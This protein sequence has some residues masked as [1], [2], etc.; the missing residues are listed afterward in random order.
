MNNDIY[1][2]LTEYSQVFRERFKNIAETTFTEMANEARVD[3]AT[4]HTT[5]KKIYKYEAQARSIKRRRYTFIAL[6]V[7]LWIILLF[8]ICGTLY[9]CIVDR[10]WEYT[11]ISTKTILVVPLIIIPVPLFAWIHPLIKKLTGEGRQIKQIIQN[12]YKEA[13]EQMEP[14]NRLYDWDVLT[15]M[16]TQTVPKLEFD[17]YFTTQRLADLKETYGWDDSFNQDRSVIYSHSGLIKGNPFIICRTRRMEMGFKTYE[18]YKTI[19]WTT[20]ERGSDGNYH[21][22]HHSQTL[23]ATITKPYPYY[24]EKSRLIYGNTAAPDLTFLRE[25]SGLADRIGSIAYKLQRRSLRKKAR[26]L[27]NANYAMMSNEEFE[28][29]FDTSNRND[30]QQHALLFTP[31]AQQ[32]MIKLLQDETE[33]YGDDFDF[34]KRRMINT[35]ISDHMQELNFDFNPKLYHN[36]DFNKAQAG[37]VQINSEY[38]RALY[39]NLAPLL[40][41]PMY[42]QIRPHHDIYGI[43]MKPQ[44]SFWEHEAQANLWGQSK[45]EHPECVTDSI[46]KT[47]IIKSENGNSEI[48]VYAHGHRAERRMQIEV[49]YGGDGRYHDVPVYW[50]EY[51]PV[52]GKGTMYIKEDNKEEKRFASHTERIE[53]INKFLSDSDFTIYRRNIAS[54]I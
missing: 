54:K 41:V 17:P 7:I 1:D 49:V 22:V 4:N 43:D 24:K 23:T 11:D 37:F 14:L 53:Y 19:H 51:I 40:C 52:T 18:G 32:S 26:N 50:D 28:V 12:L 47:E 20:T 38:F 45:F 9:I 2:P 36:F 15:R 16:I 21:T 35:I 6:C 34:E 3:I 30:N 42:Q 33:G 39:F 27:K 25:K 31:L 46:L 29:V 48:S 10:A 13:W 5:C 8:C 44:S